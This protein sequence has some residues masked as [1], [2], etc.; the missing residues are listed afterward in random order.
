MATP[1][2]PRRVARSGVVPRVQ[3]EPGEPGDPGELRQGWAAG[4]AGAA[5]AA[6][7]AAR[8]RLRRFGRRERHAETVHARRREAARDV[9]GAGLVSERPEELE[10]L[11]WGRC[12]GQRDLADAVEVEPLHQARQTLALARDAVDFEASPGGPEADGGVLQQAEQRAELRLLVFP[13][14]RLAKQGY[15]ACEP[16]SER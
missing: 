14:A 2:R 12:G 3:Q 4:A 1:Q 13:R 10:Q 5:G 16:R 9:V 11:R 7:A 15:A 8:R 6:W